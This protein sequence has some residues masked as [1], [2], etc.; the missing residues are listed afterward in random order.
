VSRAVPSAGFPQLTFSGHRPLSTVSPW[1]LRLVLGN[2]PVS[3]HRF[4]LFLSL[5]SRTVK[6]VSS[7]VPLAYIPI[8]PSFWGLMCFFLVLFL[9]LGTQ[10]SGRIFFNFSLPLFLPFP[11]FPFRSFLLLP[12]S[13]VSIPSPDVP[14]VPSFFVSF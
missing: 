9:F 5:S 13:S 1:R 10:P 2:T 3:I 6:R 7:Y 14:I 4:V 8:F 11:L 12:I